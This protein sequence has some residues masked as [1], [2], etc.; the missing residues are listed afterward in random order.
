MSFEEVKKEYEMQREN[1]RK[2]LS[3]YLLAHKGLS[4]AGLCIVT[5]NGAGKGVE[6]YTS[7]G[8]IPT[9]DLRNWKW[10]E[11]KDENGLDCVISLNMPHVD[12]GTKY[13]LSLY[14]RIGL[15]FSPNPDDW[16]CTDIDLPLDEK[17]KEKIAQLVLKQFR[18]RTQ[19][20][21]DLSD[22]MTERSEKE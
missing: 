12:N 15:L 3:T 11:V 17:K 16:I 20:K 7:G 13:I 22:D 18:N 19:P 14:D 4:A 1:E 6:K 8:E 5:G 21:T 2:A 9:F 10:V